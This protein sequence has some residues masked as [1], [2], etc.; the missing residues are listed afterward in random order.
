MSAHLTHKNDVTPVL[1]LYSFG[2]DYLSIPTD[3]DTYSAMVVQ[4]YSEDEARHLVAVKLGEFHSEIRVF[5]TEQPTPVTLVPRVVS[6]EA[7]TDRDAVAQ[8]V[9]D[10][11]KQ[12]DEIS[13]INALMEPVHN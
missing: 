4:A 10:R 12:A 9:I 3:W 1:S 13:E 6:T 5:L 8:S 11:A 2:I 7:L